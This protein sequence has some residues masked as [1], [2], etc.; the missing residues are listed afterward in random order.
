MFNN[1]LNRAVILYIYLLFIIVFMWMFL[2]NTVF[3]LSTREAVSMQGSVLDINNTIVSYI[4]KNGE[5]IKDPDQRQIFEN[6]LI[7]EVHGYRRCPEDITLYT[8]QMFN[9][10]SL[11]EKNNFNSCISILVTQVD[12]PVFGTNVQRGTKFKVRSRF[13]LKSNSFFPKYRVYHKISDVFE[14][15]AFVHRYKNTGDY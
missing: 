10:K 7:N 11:S 5:Y 6:A 15:T 4:Q 13:V 8:N 2:G 14:S 1:F 3:A 9:S 12:D